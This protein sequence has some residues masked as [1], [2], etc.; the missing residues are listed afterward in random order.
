MKLIIPCLYTSYGRYITRFRANPFCV[1]ALKPAE[2][3]TL[4]GLYEIA[5]DLVKSARVVGRIIGT[6]H[7]HGDVSTYGVLTNLVENGMAV[8]KGGW[9][10][11]GL[12]DKKPAAMRYTE[13]K[14]EKWVRELAFKYINHVPWENVEYNEEPFSLPCPVPIGLI[15][16]D[17]I[18]GISF[19]RT[20]IPRYTISDLA[21]RLTWLLE[22]GKPS[23]DIESLTEEQLAD[24]E[25]N[26]FG[27]C[28]KPNFR[29]C[30]PRASNKEFYKVL[31]TG[32]GSIEAV[33]YGKIDKGNIYIL[34][35]APGSSFKS[36][37]NATIIDPK[38][39]TRDIDAS[40]SN[41]SGKMDDRYAIKILVE[42]I[43]KHTDVNKLAQKIWNNYLIKTMNFTCYYSDV[44]GKLQLISIDDI[45]LENYAFWKTAVQTKRWKDCQAAIQSKFENY[46]IQIIRYIV[47]QYK[48]TKVSDVIN[49]YKTMYTD[50]TTNTITYADIDLDQYDSTNG[51]FVQKHTV[52][53]KDIEDV[54][55]KKSIKQLIETK[56]DMKN[57]DQKIIDTKQRIVDTDTDCAAEVKTLIK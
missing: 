5:K 7:P 41:I 20:L 11:H 28:I 16:Y 18:F 54:C 26:G 33:P 39:K 45:L 52:T 15:G 4:L 35:R 42:P 3:R 1:D 38:T 37:V 19:Y 44:V 12:T 43:G 51:W 56:I 29:D 27:P 17:A 48:C 32:E 14:L 47:E 24:E 46:V 6:Y 53:E 21:K 40:V 36:L 2:R 57:I 55:S 25:N 10:L 50:T 8:G 31:T 9:G 30:S 23:I 13:V 49:Y 22:N 34:G